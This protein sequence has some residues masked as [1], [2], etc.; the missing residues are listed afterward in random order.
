MTN[1]S[2]QTQ[3]TQLADELLA[4]RRIPRATY[5]L[6]FNQDFTFQDGKTL[7]S[8]LADLGISDCYASPILRP[9]TGS[10][11]GYDIT[12]HSQI[13]PALGGEEGFAAFAATLNEH[14]MGLVV[15]MVPNHMGIGEASNR[16]WMDV[17]ENGPGSSY[18]AYFDIDWEPVKAELANKVLLPILGD[19]YG[20]VLESGQLRLNYEEGAFWLSYY[21]TRLPIAPR[22]YS[23]ILQNLLERLLAE[24]GEDH[25]QVLELQSILTALSYLPPRT[26]PTPEK[27]AE[28]N[29]EKEIVK[30]RLITLHAASPEVAAALEATVEALNGAVGEP[31]SFDQL[32]E[33]IEAQPYRLAFWR[34]AAEEINYRR[35]FDINDL[36]AVRVELPQVFEDTHSLIFQ[37]IGEGKI[38]GLRID[39]PDGLWNPPD[40]F[41]Q[42]QARYLLLSLQARLDADLPREELEAAVMAWVSRHGSSSGAVV[43]WPLYVA[44]EKILSEREPLP[45][46]WSVAGTTGYD[47][48]NMVNNIFVDRSNRSA[49]DKIYRRFLAQEELADR[50]YFRNLVYA[51]KRLIMQASLSSEINAL[52]HQLDRIGECNRHYRDFTLLGL[53]SAITEFIA[54]LSIY[55]TYV[56]VDEGTVSQRDQQ[57]VTAAIKE[58]KKRNPQVDASVFDFI[59]DTLLLRNTGNFDEEDRAAL[60]QFVMRFQ[61][62]T[63]PVMAKGVED[64]A[65]YIYNRLVSLNEVGGHPEDF[66]VPVTTFH[67]DN[68]ARQRHWPHAMLSSSTHDTKRSED[69]RARINVLSEMPQAWGAAVERWHEQNAPHQTL[70][71]DEPVLDRNDEYLLYQTLIG[72]WPIGLLGNAADLDRTE[73]A[74]FRERITAYMQKATK[75]AKVHTSWINPN[76]AYDSAMRTFI[77]GILPEHPDTPFL[78][79]LLAFLR[80][81]AFYGWFNS[82]SQQLLKL[83]VPGV[84][85]VY[86]GTELWDLSLVDPDNRRP[87]AY[88][89]RQTL[90]SELHQRVAQSRKDLIPLAEELVEQCRDGRIKLYITWKTLGLRRDYAM[91]FSEGRYVPLEAVGDKR[92]HVCAFAR[93]FEE[94]EILVVASR[95]VAGL[96]NGQESAPMG[97]EVWG[98]TLLALPESNPGQRFRNL[99]TGET[100]TVE[101]QEGTIVLSL[102]SICGHFPVALLQA[103]D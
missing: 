73:Y 18:A 60:G 3:V 48:L 64:T 88:S 24:L 5:R 57:F 21:E 68:A 45:R 84:P 92:D 46:D 55:R 17:L 2:V 15:D 62:I 85:D 7:I 52:S 11:H 91:L 49:F 70:V 87:V 81:V 40:Y 78:Q 31:K 59:Q 10:T 23:A 54:C 26:E 83:T 44:V 12:D 19:Q 29:R 28:R 56:Q 76:E 94:Q 32:D 65:F 20:S 13:S 34:V 53:T 38:T 74:A 39:H 41:R 1:A 72:A 22:T 100:L 89:H 43:D 58:A 71:E 79:D 27:L 97:G 33:V 25:E 96:C 4:Q 77:N 47:F 80:P 75:E 67:R 93:Q 103:L 51:K 16:W 36:A 8:Y 69:V 82:L 66:G 86:Q 63:G 101:E 30:R 42:L 90:L 61:Q 98:D 99:F 37:L 102:A 95:L 50:H 14:G 35:F 9:R 6:Q